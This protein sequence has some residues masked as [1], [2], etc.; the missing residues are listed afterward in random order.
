MSENL[1]DPNITDNEALRRWVSSLT[2]EALLKRGPLSDALTVV[3]YEI[4]AATLST[5]ATRGGGP[6]FR[7][8]GRKPLYRWGD[9]LA[10]AE[11]RMTAPMCSTSELDRATQRIVTT[12]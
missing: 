12:A 3:G 4:S 9:A 10:W 7:R 2:P 6:P 11:S 8:F 1:S 5:M